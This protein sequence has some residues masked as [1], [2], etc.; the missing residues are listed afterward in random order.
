MCTKLDI[1]VFSTSISISD[2]L[3]STIRNPMH[4][5]IGAAYLYYHILKSKKKDKCYIIS[6]CL[7]D[8]DYKWSVIS[9]D[10]T[11]PIL[12]LMMLIKQ[13]TNIAFSEIVSG[14]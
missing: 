3:T 14:E 11:K 4:K 6:P 12:I 5:N 7:I 2:I 9:Y 1:Y 13:I 10:Q 8:A